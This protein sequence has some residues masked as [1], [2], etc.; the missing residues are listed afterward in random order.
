ME[1]ESPVFTPNN[2]PYLGRA[3]LLEFD[4]TIFDAMSRMEALNPRGGT[5]YSELQKAAV[6]LAPSGITLTLSIRELI[7]QGYLYG[8]LALVRPLLE[9]TVTLRYLWKK[10]E[11]IQ[12]WSEGWPYNKRPRL[13][14]MIRSMDEESA[15]V[16]RPR[17]EL[18]DSIVH[19]SPGAFDPLAFFSDDGKAKIAIGRNLKRPDICDKVAGLATGALSSLVETAEAILGR[20]GN[21]KHANP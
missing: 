21:P 9:R 12:L 16:G 2:E 6:H 20:N 17:D 7:R 8:S 1:E 10:P 11:A 14:E 3:L 5:R 13:W 18:L 4:L 19:G 15:I